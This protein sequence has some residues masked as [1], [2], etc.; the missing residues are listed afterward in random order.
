MSASDLDPH[1][2]KF[3]KELSAAGA[4]MSAGLALLIIGVP[5]VILFLGSVRVLSL[6]EGRLVEV[7]L[8][9]RMPRR[10]LYSQRDH[11][12]PDRIKG[13]FTD[14]RSWSTLL[15][16]IAMMPLGV[17]YFTLALVGQMPGAAFMAAPL[18]VAFGSVN[19]GLW[20][21]NWQVAS[22]ASWWWELSL[23]FVAGVVLLFA[24]LHLARG[25]GLLHG[26]F[27]KHLLVKTAQYG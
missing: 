4:A 2:R 11:S 3:Q 21:D 6:V 13:M 22:E 14:P 10:P 17:V 12:L 24:T 5:F 7:M 1:L 18:A 27:A 20:L 9:E 16:M 25:I 15:Y 19:G 23:L 26:R 8:G